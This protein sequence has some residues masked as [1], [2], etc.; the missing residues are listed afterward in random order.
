MRNEGVFSSSA[1]RRVSVLLSWA[2]SFVVA[3]KFV[4]DSQEAIVFTHLGKR[5]RRRGRCCDRTGEIRIIPHCQMNNQWRRRRRD[6]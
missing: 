2:R 6:W 5:R 1:N 4:G 3:V